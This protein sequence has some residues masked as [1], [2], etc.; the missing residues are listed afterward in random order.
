MEVTPITISYATMKE[1]RKKALDVLS[2]SKEE[3][4]KMK[5]ELETAY[6]DYYVQLYTIYNTIAGWGYSESELKTIAANEAKAVVDSMS[7]TYIL[8]AVVREKILDK[9]YESYD[10]NTLVN[11]TSYIA[12]VE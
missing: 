10:V 1:A 9:I 11:W 3:T 7:D 8:E 12:D 2:V 4:S 6:N 5:A